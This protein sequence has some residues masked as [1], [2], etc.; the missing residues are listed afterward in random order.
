MPTSTSPQRD[1]RR[2]RVR[3]TVFGVAA[4]ALVLAGCIA[5][6]EEWGAHDT[7]LMGHGRS[8]AR[9]KCAGCHTVSGARPS[10]NPRAPSFADI[11]RRYSRSGLDRE[12]EA[13]SEVGHYAMPT[14]PLTPAERESLAAYIYK[15]RAGP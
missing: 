14:T 1:H 11:S 13:I 3:W 6:G 12:F 5:I 8:V 2:R 4:A 10:P 7:A 15:G 9:E